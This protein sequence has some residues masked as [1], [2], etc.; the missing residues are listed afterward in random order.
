MET[1]NDFGKHAVG[2]HATL[3]NEDEQS[4]QIIKSTSNLDKENPMEIL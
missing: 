4:S 3:S 2:M 1:N